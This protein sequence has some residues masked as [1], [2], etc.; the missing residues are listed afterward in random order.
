M[1]TA[2]HPRRPVLGCKPAEALF[3]TAILVT[4]PGIAP[5][6]ADA[7]GGGYSKPYALFEPQRQMQVADTRPAFV[8]KIDGRNVSID[9]SEPVA[10]GMR[11][12]VV[13]IP[14]PKGTS[15][16]GRATLEVDA[17]PCTRY[18]L[19]ARRSS[20]TARD[21]SAFVAA[22]EPIGDCVR[23]FPPT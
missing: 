18:Y 5:L 17:K 3:A 4:A 15:N 16:P 2:K 10:P 22:S 7:A 21:W 1:A 23:R 13:S 12:V 11:T 8:V 6:T 14:G 9:R 20:P 19:A